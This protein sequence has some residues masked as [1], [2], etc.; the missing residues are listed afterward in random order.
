M[1]GRDWAVRH[2]LTVT[3]VY[4]VAFYWVGKML[5]IQIRDDYSRH[6][7]LVDILTKSADVKKIPP[8]RYKHA[9]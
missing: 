4:L 8:V 2:N 5:N 9:K 3:D 6:A 1:E 7:R